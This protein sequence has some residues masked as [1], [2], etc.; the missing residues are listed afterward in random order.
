MI[1]GIHHN[2]FVEVEVLSTPKLLKLCLRRR[3]TQ[4]T[5]GNHIT[6]SLV[7]IRVIELELIS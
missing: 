6:S 7:S 1:L 2:G 4:T 5:F 3:Q